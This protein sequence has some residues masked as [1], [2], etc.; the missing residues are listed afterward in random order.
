MHREQSFARPSVHGRESGRGFH[1]DGDGMG[2]ASRFAMFNVNDKVMVTGRVEAHQG[3]DLHGK[4]LKISRVDALT[5]MTD[6]GST[7][8]REVD[9]GWN[10]LVAG[11]PS[12]VYQSGLRIV[13]AS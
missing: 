12:N 10:T 7:W 13:R 11:A 2:V 4:V 5:V 8:Y 1:V 6:D 9:G 3:S